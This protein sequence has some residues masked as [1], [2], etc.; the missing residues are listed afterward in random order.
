MYDNE[1]EAM[2]KAL[3][4]RN[5]ADK[6]VSVYVS[7]LKRFFEQLTIPLDQ[8]QPQTIEDW[9]YSLVER[10]VSWTLFNQ[11]VCYL[12]FRQKSITLILARERLL[13]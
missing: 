1:L 3:V 6:T 13:H 8:I 10:R 12:R 11:M 2:R 5:Y 4:I 7:V 9:Q